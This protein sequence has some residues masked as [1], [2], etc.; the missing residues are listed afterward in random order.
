LIIVREM[1]WMVSLKEIVGGDYRNISAFCMFLQGK[2]ETPRLSSR[3]RG[4]RC[5][6]KR[7]V[8]NNKRSINGRYPKYHLQ[9][10]E[11]IDQIGSFSRDCPRPVIPEGR[12]RG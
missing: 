3:E 6:W 4:L 2:M 7:Y 5:C 9:I 12:L 1:A 11:D 10:S 8:F